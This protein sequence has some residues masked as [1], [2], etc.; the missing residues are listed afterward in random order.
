MKKEILNYYN[1]LAN[2]YDENR[3]SNTYGK[4]INSQE[5]K[6]IKKYLDKNNITKNLDIACGTGRFLNFANYGIDISSE[7]VKVSKD[8]FPSKK[9]IVSDAESMPFNDLFF[10][11]ALAFHL[12]MHLDINQHERILNEVARVIKKDGYFIFDVPS[13]KRRK[14]TNYKA[15]SWHGGNQINV[16]ELK[17]IISN[18]WELVA[19]HGIAFFP[20]HRI[21]KRFRKFF[22]KLDNFFSNSFAREY[23]SHLIFILRKK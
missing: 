1:K 8:K 18:N 13:K 5:N 23:S 21:P 10:N 15:S 22:I 6:V 3:F 7:M 12:F 14:F 4:Y 16:S 20:I 11:N 9:I 19:Y 17:T 2:T